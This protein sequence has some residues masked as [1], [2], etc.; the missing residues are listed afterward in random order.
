MLQRIFSVKGYFICF[1]VLMVFAACQSND[2]NEHKAFDKVKLD[3]ENHVV[4]VDTVTPAPRK[5]PIKYDCIDS[6]QLFES[7]VI[8]LITRNENKIKTIKGTPNVSMKLLKRVTTIEKA[9][10]EMRLLLTAYET[11]ELE[12]WLAF[13]LQMRTDLEMLNNDILELNEMK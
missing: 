5:E 10:N 8:R 6:F 7:E 3:K 12:R 4:S 1:Q 13:K 9:N 11:K 2:Y